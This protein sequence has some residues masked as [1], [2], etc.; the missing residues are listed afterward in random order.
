M[1]REEAEKQYTFNMMASMNE[2]TNRFLIHEIYDDF[3]SRTCENCKIFTQNGTCPIY[4][5]AYNINL[6]K[7]ETDFNCSKWKIKDRL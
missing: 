2:F 3:E 5:E 7:D 4:Y 6:A 1:T